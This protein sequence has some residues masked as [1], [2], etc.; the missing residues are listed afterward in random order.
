MPV[1]GT[2]MDAID[3]AAVAEVDEVGFG[4]DDT[5]DTERTG[6]RALPWAV[7]GN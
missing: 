4:A 5:G 7:P 3:G 1:P 2:P 6:Q